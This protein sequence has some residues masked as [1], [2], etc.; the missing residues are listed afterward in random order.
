MASGVSLPGSEL[1]AKPSPGYAIPR[2]L[3]ESQITA[4]ILGNGQATILYLARPGLMA[5]LGN[6][7]IDLPQAGGPDGMAP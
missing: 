6:Q 4:A 1:S 5:Q 3:L 2:R 7:F